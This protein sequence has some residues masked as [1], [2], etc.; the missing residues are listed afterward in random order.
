MAELV[1]QDRLR[2]I[3][4]ATLKDEDMACAVCN[5]PFIMGCRLYRDLNGKFIHSWCKT[6]LLVRMIQVYNPTVMDLFTTL[7]LSGR[8]AYRL[9]RRAK[10]GRQ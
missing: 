7:G 5:I 2:C 4:K 9:L 1:I 10:Y 3:R 6:E 8:T